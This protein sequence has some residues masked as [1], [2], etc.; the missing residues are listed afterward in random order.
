M[1]DVK[2]PAYSQMAVE[3]WDVILKNFS[4]ERVRGYFVGEALAYLMRYDG[5]NDSDRGGVRDLKK[6][7]H[8]L[9]QLIQYEE[10]RQPGQRQVDTPA[11]VSIPRTVVQYPEWKPEDTQP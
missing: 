3:P 6:A 8:F 5:P 1:N 11:G 7:R 2:N 10:G 4:A 9:D